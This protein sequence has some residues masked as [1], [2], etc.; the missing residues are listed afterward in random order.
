MNGTLLP[1]LIGRYRRAILAA[2]VFSFFFNILVL[3]LPFYMLS[4]FTRVLMSKSLETL[5]LL[6]VAA[7]VALVIQ[8]ILDFIRSGVLIRVGVALDATLTGKVLESII[9]NAA[10]SSVRNSRRLADAAELRNFLSGPNILSLFDAPFTPFYVVVIYLLHPVLGSLALAGALLL[11]AIAVVNELLTRGPVKK[12]MESSF[13]AQ[14]RVEEY[15]RNADAVEAMGMLPSVMSHWRSESK[16]SMDYQAR[17]VD[18]ASATRSLAKFVRLLLQ[19]GLFGTGAYLYLQ[20]QIMPGVIIAASILMG[21]A[22]SPVEAA[23]TSWKGL[24]RA[25]AAYGRLQEVLS[26]K[27]VR[28]FEGQMSLPAPEGRLQLERILYKVPVPGGDKMILKGVSFQL[29]PGEFLGVIGPS[30]AG[31]STLAKVVVGILAPQNGVARLDGADLSSWNPDELGRH[32][33]YLPQDVQMFSGS[34]GENIARLTPEPDSQAVLDAAQMA[35]VHDT[36]LKLPKGYDTDVGAAGV[37]LSAG[38]RQHIALAR[39]FYGKPQLLV[40]DEPNSNL[41]AMSEDALLRAL[42]RAKSEGVTI[43]VV[44]HRPSIL[45]SADKLLMLR[46]GAIELF[47]KREDVMARLSGKSPAK[48]EGNLHASNVVAR[49]GE[50]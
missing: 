26:P 27:G 37:F 14:G 2:A 44:T 19:I 3:T 12:G 25:K 10:G 22:L 31:K 24:V 1:Q 40:L 36:I 20:N 29:Q 8:A 21:R 6:S 16:E 18:Y 33:G 48:P 43:L 50:G 34:V 17:A 11:F 15:V 30:G 13:K 23:I 28:S 47:G 42:A 38:Q 32:I 7:F 4:V 49:V 41:D 5:V 39:A 35:G 9:R 46:D 45:T